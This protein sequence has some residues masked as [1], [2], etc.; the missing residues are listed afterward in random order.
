MLCLKQ[1]WQNYK[2][3]RANQT[4][5]LGCLEKLHFKLSWDTTHSTTTWPNLIKT[6]ALLLRLYFLVSFLFCV[7]YSQSRTYLIARISKLT[8]NAKGIFRGNVMN[9]FQACFSVLDNAMPLS[10]RNQNAHNQSFKMRY[11]ESMYT[12]WDN[13]RNLPKKWS[14]IARI[15]KVAL[16]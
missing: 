14:K 15:V 10:F 2:N 4:N 6:W 13:W 3:L 1:N 8:K 12:F 5:F 7:F 9:S 16:S 11:C